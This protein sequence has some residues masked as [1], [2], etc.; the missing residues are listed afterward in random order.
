MPTQTEL[1]GKHPL[2]PNIFG[3]WLAS[4][5]YAVTTSKNHRSLTPLTTIDN[6]EIIEWLGR[7]LFK[8]HHTDYRIEKLKEN[9]SQLGFSE[10]AK[11]VENRRRLPLA[12]AVQKGNATEI[13]LT[14]YIQDCLDKELIKVFK[15][16][17]NP[18]VDQAIKGDDTLM[19]DIIN[20]GIQDRI[21]L[22]LGESKFRSIPTK[23][24]I[25][26]LSQ[27]LSKDKLPLSYTFLIDELGRDSANK[28][29]ADLLDKTMISQIKGNDD[30]IYTG[31]LLSDTTT[32]SV[33]EKHLNSDNSQMILISIGIDD[34]AELI[35]KGF[36]R[37]NYYV[38]NPELI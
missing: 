3:K 29:I 22:Y 15:L 25:N 19:V 28:H 1:I 16:K 23:A 18:N 26:T 11:Y 20:D 8:H 36:E 17:Y 10:Y 38:L 24:V 35:K 31:M 21:K 34:P 30:L 6:N 12:D 27:S 4:N 37:A 32:S 13:V 5:D 7:A 33:V 2:S 14:E 9:Y